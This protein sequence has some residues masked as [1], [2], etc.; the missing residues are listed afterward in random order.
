[1]TD[2]SKIGLD[3]PYCDATI[4][5]SIDWFKQ[6]YMSCPEC[7]Q[8]L[9]GAQFCAVISDLEEEIDRNIEEMLRPKTRG[10][11]GDKQGCC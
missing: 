4:Y 8:G 2:P 9:A 11:C 10:C 5:Q 6:S 1:M 7:G 3:C